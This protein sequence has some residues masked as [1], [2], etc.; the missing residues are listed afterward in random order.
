LAEAIY[1]LRGDFCIA[2]FFA[3]TRALAA[4]NFLFHFGWLW[5]L[6]IF[7]AAV[8]KTAKH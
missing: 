8:A 1:H 3:T 7:A 4:V 6:F 2:A 5:A